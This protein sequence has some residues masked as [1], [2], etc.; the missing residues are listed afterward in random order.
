ML[1]PYDVQRG[2]GAHEAAH[3]HRHLVTA[4]VELRF[5]GRGKKEVLVKAETDGGELRRFT[6]TKHAVHCG[7]LHR[8]RKGVHR[9]Q[10]HSVDKQYTGDIR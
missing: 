2:I 5:L 8:A 7:K 10:A 9:A 4:E 1:L 3:A 6:F